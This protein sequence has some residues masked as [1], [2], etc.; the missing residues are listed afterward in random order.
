MYQNKKEMLRKLI[1]I[2]FGCLFILLSASTIIQDNQNSI[3]TNPSKEFI[4][5]FILGWLTIFI[6]PVTGAVLM[7]KN[8]TL[9]KSIVSLYIILILSSVAL[10]LI[11]P[12]WLASE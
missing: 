3:F 12:G 10:E 11:F 6:V 8:Y 1:A 5:E 4:F 7:Y 2:I 9:G